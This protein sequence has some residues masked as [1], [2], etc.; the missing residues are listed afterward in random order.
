MLQ[1]IETYEESSTSAWMS[2]KRVFYRNVAA[3]NLGIPLN[4]VKG[5]RKL[6]S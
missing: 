3:I 2:F 1:H 4:D 6:L 5:T